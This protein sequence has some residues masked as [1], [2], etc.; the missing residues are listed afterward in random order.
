MKL[1]YRGVS[2]EYDPSKLESQKRGQPFKQV[3]G[4]GSAYNLIYRG[5]SYHIDPNAK[6]SEVPVQPVAYRLRYIEA[7]RTL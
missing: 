7:S 4:S 5:V 1:Y 2:Y 6:L 3:C